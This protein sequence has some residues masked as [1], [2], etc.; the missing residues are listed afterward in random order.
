LTADPF[1]I[2]V[3][4][5]SR[6]LKGAQG[7]EGKEG[8]GTDETE[9]GSGGQWYLFFEVLFGEK[10]DGN[11]PSSCDGD[12]QIGYAEDVSADG[13]MSKW[14]YG[15]LVATDVLRGHSAY[16]YVFESEGSFWMLPVG[17]LSMLSIRCAVVDIVCPHAC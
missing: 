6:R 7:A 9:A 11:S 16:P 14:R 17:A 3:A 2:H 8:A 1:L 13:S 10:G 5:A 12:G 4:G 15:G